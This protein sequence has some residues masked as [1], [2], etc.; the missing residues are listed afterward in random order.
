MSRSIVVK[1]FAELADVLNL[2][3]LSE[4]PA[5]EAGDS[6]APSATQET[7]VS[8]LAGL[9]AELETASATLAAIARRDQEARALALL[10]LEQYDALV[11][12]QQEAE[13][14]CQRARQVRLESEALVAAAFAEEAR[15]AA[16][17]TANV[18]AR[19]EAAAAALADQCGHET[20]RLAAQLDLERLLAERRRQEEA[21]KAKAAEAEQ[22]WRLS[23][24]LARTREAL[25]AGRFEEAKGLL[26][27]VAGEFPDSPEINSLKQ[28]IAQ[29][30]LDVKLSAAEETLWA[31]RREF[32]RD[33]AATLARLEAL[34]VEG[35]PEDLTRQLFGE[36]ARA[37]ARLCRD[38][39]IAEPLR[40][41]PDPGRGAVIARESPGGS[42]VVVSA[43]GMGPN[44]QPGSVVG[45]RQ[46]RRARPLR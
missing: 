23:G 37:C 29:R 35:L 34:D 18:A 43:L 41:A 7:P 20:E 45:E 19:T 12:R 36:W 9:L 10:D 22:A 6:A 8:D 1:S 42:Y 13:R 32:R 3:D 44:W 11:A 40:Y 16:K 25:E 28:I 5:A 39:E 26:G 4:G 24:A 17:R 38:R 2:D 15:V 21:E 33:P 27:S 30:E 31:A 46:V 14:A